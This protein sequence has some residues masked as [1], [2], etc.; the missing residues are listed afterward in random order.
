M[1]PNQNEVWLADLGMVGKV[2]PVIIVS[3]NDDDPPRCLYA[4]VP[5]TSQYRESPYEV[6]LGRL[7]FLSKH[8]YANVQGVGSLPDPRMIR[9]LGNLPEEKVV[10]LQAAISYLYDL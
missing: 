2:R 10:A 5:L 6:D 3:R 1:M 9:K 8:S 4:Y 7:P